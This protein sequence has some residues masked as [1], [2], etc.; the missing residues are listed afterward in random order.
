MIFLL[1]EQRFILTL[2]FASHK[3]VFASK[4]F[5]HY[6]QY[7]VCPFFGI[8]SGAYRAHHV[9]MHHV[10]NNVFP[11]DV[12]STMSYQRDSL[13]HFLCYWIRY[14][15][16]IWFQLPYYAYT[17]QRYMLSLHTIL[18]CFSYLTLVYE[19]YQ[20]S[21]VATTYVFILPYLITSFLLMFGNW[22]QHIF[23][24]PSRYDDSYTITYN[25]IN[26]TMNKLTYNDGY[27]IVHHINSQLH[28]SQLPVYFNENMSKFEENGSLT[29]E[30]LE[31]VQIGF[32]VLLGKL[33]TLAKHYVHLGK[34]NTKKSD[35]EIIQKLK[36]WLV[37]ISPKNT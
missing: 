10:E 15:F 28:W 26:S 29:F 35:Q 12:S 17:R 34:Q 7:I 37:P 2:H 4:W 33:D 19:L 21:P 31:Y 25:L 36:A 24:N 23:I 9:V 13:Y 30:G 27:H 20:I 22:S 32:Y 5:D 1:Y 8:P 6:L 18:W 11:Y 3:A 14:L 16:A